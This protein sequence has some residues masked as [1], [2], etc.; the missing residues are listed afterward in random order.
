MQ[1]FK[2]PFSKCNVDDVKMLNQIHTYCSFFEGRG[3]GG[4][5]INGKCI[6]LFSGQ[7]SPTYVLIWFAALSLLSW[8]PGECICVENGKKCRHC[9]TKHG[10]FSQMTEKLVG[11]N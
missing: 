6:P 3:G 7:V 1:V 10:S 11:R 9:F 5:I 8:Q 2:L 4:I